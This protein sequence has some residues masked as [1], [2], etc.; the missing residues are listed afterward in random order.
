MKV[1]RLLSLIVLLV[2]AISVASALGVTPARTTVGFTPGM[3]QEISFTVVNSE[4]KDI[5][6]VVYVKGELNQTIE[7]SETEFDM[8]STLESKELKYHFTLPD[9]LSPGPHTAEILIMQR[10][11]NAAVSEAFVGATVAVSHQLVVNVPYPGKYARADMNVLNANEHNEVTFI[12]PIISLG[13][14]DIEQ[15]HAIISIYD[16]TGDKL[17]QFQTDSISVPTGQRKEI[18]GKW[19]A[20]VPLG[21]YLAKAHVVYSGGEID[22][23]K[24]FAVG[25]ET[26][27]LQRVTVPSFSLGGIAK[28]E[29]LIENKWSEPIAGAYAQTQVFDKNGDI[30]ADFKSPTYDV[31][32]L[33]KSTFVSYWDT[34][35]INEGTYDTS[36]YMR[37][38]SKYSKQDIQLQVS[39]NE[40]V[41]LGLGFVI[42]EGKGG[43]SS[44]V[45]ILIIVIVVLVL[46]NLLWFFILRKKMKK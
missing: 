43:K 42:S 2:L 32:A 22:L 24:E 3:E 12:I 26:L 23:E 14:Q 7:F 39:S 27:E 16:L 17:D 33:N 34:A 45:T 18:V 41:A 35:G 21:R 20:N 8:P 6:L 37:Y 31:P 36:V 30:M 11:E 44:L 4:Y 29:M 40:I 10:A 13:E 38:G 9:N 1:N 28:F 25:N 19:T 46:L 15:A 5:H